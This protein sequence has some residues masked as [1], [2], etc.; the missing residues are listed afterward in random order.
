MTL[1][2][3]MSTLIFW[4]RVSGAAVREKNKVADKRAIVFIA[5][6]RTCDGLNSVFMIF[7]LTPLRSSATKGEIEFFQKTKLVRPV[8]FGVPLSG[9]FLDR[10]SA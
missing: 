3:L 4:A 10:N 6:R 8:T 5:N 2:V 7:P 1:S 9:G